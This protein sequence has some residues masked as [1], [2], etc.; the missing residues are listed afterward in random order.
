MNYVCD[1]CGGFIFRERPGVCYACDGSLCD[2]C[3]KD[4]CENCI[5]DELEAGG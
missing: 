1:N 2:F 4:L 3:D 5:E